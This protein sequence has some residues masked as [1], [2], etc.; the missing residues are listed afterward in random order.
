MNFLGH[1]C[2]SPENEIKIGPNATILLLLSLILVLMSCAHFSTHKSM[3]ERGAPWEVRGLRSLHVNVCPT[4]DA[5]SNS[6]WYKISYSK[7][8]H[9]VVLVHIGTSACCG[10][11]SHLLEEG[12]T[13]ISSLP[14][15]PRIYQLKTLP[16]RFPTFR[17]LLR[18]Y[19]PDEFTD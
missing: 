14:T 4:L 18:F 12:T 2:S 9:R 10:F 15:N 8:R 6:M 1:S 17:T 13:L 5:M 7:I 11:E 16:T 3:S 19:R